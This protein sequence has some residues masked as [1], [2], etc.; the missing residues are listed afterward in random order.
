MCLLLYFPVQTVYGEKAG[1][2]TETE[3][4]FVKDGTLPP[5]ISDSTDSSE[6]EPPVKKGLLPN[7]GEMIIA[8]VT[9]AGIIIFIIV[10]VVYV[11]KK[12]WKEGKK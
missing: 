10:L 2:I 1:I 8:G 6:P 4:G 5:E 3:A 11:T 12:G 9:S 7:T